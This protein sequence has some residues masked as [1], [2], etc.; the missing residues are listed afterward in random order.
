MPRWTLQ[1]KR[2]S[3]SL[4]MRKE[5]EDVPFSPQSLVPKMIFRKK[6]SYK[7]LL[8]D[9]DDT[10]QR[11]GKKNNDDISKHIG[12]IPKPVI[13][14]DSKLA[15]KQIMYRNGV[16]VSAHDQPLRRFDVRFD[17]SRRSKA[18]PGKIVV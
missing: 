5:E 9:L 3:T 16:V 1:Q 7:N 18:V 6:G 4:L 15:S 17:D 14:L 10:C 13:P 12:E 8:V 11:N 2:H